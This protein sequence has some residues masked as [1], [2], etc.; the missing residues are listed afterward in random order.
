MKPVLTSRSTYRVFRDRVEVSR[1]AVEREAVAVAI[2]TKQDNPKAAVH[3]D[4]DLQI[5]VEL[6]D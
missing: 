2:C 3:I 6:E 5:D 1:H 4:H